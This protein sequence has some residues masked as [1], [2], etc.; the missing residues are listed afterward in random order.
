M[1]DD[2]VLDKPHAVALLQKLSTDDKF[3]ASY[4]EN[5]SGALTSIGIPANTLPGGMAPIKTLADKSVFAAALA[6]VQADMANV[7]T[8]QVPPQIRFSFGS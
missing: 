5:P 6:Q 7:C 1:A 4:K 3:R 2:T 8:C